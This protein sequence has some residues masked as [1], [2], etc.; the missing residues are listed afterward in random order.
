[1][2][3]PVD[4]PQFDPAVSNSNL[5]RLPSIVIRHLSMATRATITFSQT[6]N[7]KT[8]SR[9]SLTAAIPRDN[10][11]YSDLTVQ[12]I[13]LPEIDLQITVIYV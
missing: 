4:F 2:H 9:A 5:T 3:H 8:S 6:L 11:D 12:D 1:M 13:Y 10:P 7:A